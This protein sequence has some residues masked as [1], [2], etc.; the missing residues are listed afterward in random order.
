MCSNHQLDWVLDAEAEGGSRW[1][2]WRLAADLRKL[3]TATR[4]CYSR[5]VATGRVEDLRA[6]GPDLCLAS[7]PEGLKAMGLRTGNRA[8]LQPSRE[9]LVLKPFQLRLA[10]RLSTE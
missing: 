2:L 9:V 5:A 10:D 6:T 4:P 7:Q 1:R 3:R 8:A